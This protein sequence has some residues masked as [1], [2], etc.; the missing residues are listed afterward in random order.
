M[1]N[2]WQEVKSWNVG[3]SDGAVEKYTLSKRPDGGFKVQN[4]FGNVVIDMEKMSGIEFFKRVLREMEG[5]SQGDC[6][7]WLDDMFSSDSDDT[8]FNND[9]DYTD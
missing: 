1:K 7:S 6:D 2:D 8:D 5:V 3:T 4:D 9:C